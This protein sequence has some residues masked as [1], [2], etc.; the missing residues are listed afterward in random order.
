MTSKSGGGVWCESASAVC[1]ELRADGQFGL[2]PRRRGILWHA[3]QLHAD[4]QFGLAHGGG[5]YYGTLNNCT[6]T[7]NSASIYGG[8]AY[9][10]TLNNCTLTGNS[11]SLRRRGIR[12]HAQQLHADGNSATLAAAGPT[13][14]RSTTA[15]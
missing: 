2:L 3:Q 7:G 1:L 12:W 6:L 10:G 14:A 11:A 9:C 15:R 8:G 13:M 5:A 4:G